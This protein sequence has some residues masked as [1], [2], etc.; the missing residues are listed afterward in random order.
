MQHYNY[1]DNHNWLQIDGST[2]A[3]YGESYVNYVLATYVNRK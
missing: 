3:I 2:F 1:S